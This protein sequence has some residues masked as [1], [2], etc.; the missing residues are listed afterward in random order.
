MQFHIENMTCEG[1]VRSVT[2]AIHSVDPAASVGADPNSRTADVVSDKPRAL[3]EAALAN[4]GYPSVSSHPQ[5]RRTSRGC[6]GG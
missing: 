4:A 5:N 3:L 2:K 1:C 6:C